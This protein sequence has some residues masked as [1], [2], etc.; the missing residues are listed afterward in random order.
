V[1]ELVEGETL[2]D[3]VARGPLPLSDALTI[4]RQ[5]ADALEA[6][7]ERGIIHRDLKPANIK[8]TPDDVVKVLDFGLAK[9]SAGDG[10]APGLSNSPTMTGSTREGTI[11]GTPAYMS[12]E[13]ARGRPVDKRTDVWAFGCLFYEMLTGRAAFPGET[14]TDTLAAILERE[15]NWSALPE[16]TPVS[17]R[18]LLHRCFE[19]DAKRRLR[20][21]GEARLEIETATANLQVPLPEV[22]PQSVLRGHVGARSWHRWMWAVPAVL[23]AAASFAWWVWQPPQDTQPLRATPL[24][25]LPGVE[26]HPSFSPDGNHVA[27]SWNGPRQD[28]P[29]VY[30][31]QIGSGSPLRLTTDPGNDYTPAWSPDGRWIAFLRAQG[32]A[33]A[34]ELR[35]VPPLGGPE[36]KLG[37]IRLRAEM[38]RAVSIAWCPDSSCLIVT[39]SAGEGKPDAL[40]VVSLASGEKRQLTH[41]APPVSA[42]L[43]PAVA[44]DGSWLVFSRNSTPVNGELFR[45][46]LGTGL[47]AAGEPSPLPLGSLKGRDVAWM[48]DGERI[49]FSSNGGLWTLP[50]LGAVAP[51]RVPFVGENGLMP[52]VSRPL[53]GQ[54]VRL[55]YVYSY[56]DQNIWRIDTPG[57]GAPATSAPVVAISST[58][59]DHTPQFSPDGRRVAFTSARSGELEIWLADPDGSNAVQLT[60]MGAI[61]GFARWSP[62]GNSIVFHSDPEGQAE[63]YLVS[64]AG[65]NPRNLTSHPSLDAFPNFSPDGRWIYFQSNRAEGNSIWKVP[66]SGGDPVQVTNRPGTMSQ[67]SPNGAD[68][69]YVET[70]DRP[71]PLWRLPLSG[72]VA[73]KVLEGV[74]RSNFTVLAGGIYYIDQPSGEARL[75]YFDFA[76]AR[77]RTVA[78]NLGNVGLGLTASPDGRTI[79]YT[80]ND[81]SVDDLM[82]VENFR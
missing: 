52:A 26:R 19:K 41:P 61:P 6:A 67:T 32:L 60:S 71:S 24:T 81:S 3:R 12:P 25:T 28:N 13:Q 11:L 43:W 35:L 78:R 1:L 79:L 34:N 62:D 22:A 23:L 20:D 10:S 82:L 44:P 76:T 8:I 36:R 69:Y 45:L 37:E 14:V 77:S 38:L 18:R 54:P 59:E 72:G 66:S 74:V 65:G 42:D 57:P 64:A 63:A 4:A 49:L 29:D 21:I 5:V 2:S 9:A 39:D 40:F 55:V 7:H 56:Q 80:R 33:G 73:T 75:Q 68:L 70:F 17:I 15:P 30:V 58:K 31:Q 47:I 48:P 53:P 46:R 50:V 16:S 27:F 51:S